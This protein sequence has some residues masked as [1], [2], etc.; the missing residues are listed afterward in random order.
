M[1]RKEL[2]EKNRLLEERVNSISWEEMEA[3]GMLRWASEAFPRRA[4]LA[5]SFQSTG[6]AMLHM[7]I[8]Q[9][10]EMRFATLDTLRMHPETYE[11]M[12]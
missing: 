5:T 11:F 12:E 1:E 6:M 3:A 7:A 8:E 10:L 4:V 2:E 9:G